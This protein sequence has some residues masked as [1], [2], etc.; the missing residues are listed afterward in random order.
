MKVYIVWSVMRSDY[1]RYVHAVF[2]DRDKAQ[3]LID[4]A[5]A[6][7]TASCGCCTN[8]S[9]AQILDIKEMYIEERG[10]NE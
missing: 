9:A 10:V 7:Q 5:M 6:E 8:P 1:A 4:G 3:R 2:T